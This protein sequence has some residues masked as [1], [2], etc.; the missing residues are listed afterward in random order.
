MRKDVRVWFSK[1]GT[2]R[3][4]SHLDLNRCMSRAFHKAKLP[5]WYTEG[6]NPHVFLTFA[7]P[8][9]LG[10]EGRHESMDIRLVED[11]PYPELI[12]KLNAGLP[13][14]IRVWAVTEPEMKGND[15]A[16]AEYVLRLEAEDPKAEHAA[17]EGLLALPEITVQKHAKKG[18]KFVDIKPYFAPMR[19]EEEPGEL[20]MTVR[21]PAGNQ[22]GINPMLFVDAA[23]KL[24]NRELLVRVERTRLFDKDF[25]EFR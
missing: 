3:Y 24:L 19:F 16:N 6:F 23:E 1:T 9:S 20:K 8:L 18:E 25:R 13:H 14:D 4:I 21:L 12:E 7:A 10:F 17:L 22:G 15:V 2:A 5:L 11:M